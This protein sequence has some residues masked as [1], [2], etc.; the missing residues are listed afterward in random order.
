[1]NGTEVARHNMPDGDIT[2]FTY[3]STAR[4]VATAD[5]DPVVIDVPVGLLVSGTNVVTAETHL[6]YRGTRDVSFS[7]DAQLVATAQ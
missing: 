2:H 5:A 7:L 4:N 1:M 3:A 6:K